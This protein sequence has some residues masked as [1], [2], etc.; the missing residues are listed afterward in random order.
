VI[1][2]PYLGWACGFFDFDLDGDEDL[3]MFN[4]H[5]YPE[6]TMSTMDSD[7]EQVPLL[8]A[9]DGRKFRRVNAETAGAWL[10]Q[11][12]RDRS[13]VFGDLDGDGDID[14]IVNELNGPIRVLRNDAL[15][16]AP[17]AAEWLIVTL[18]DDRADSKNRDGLG[19]R[20]ALR[21][22]GGRVQR[23]WIYSGGGFQSSDPHV[24]H[25]GIVPEERQSLTL[26][27]VWPDGLEQTIE[28]VQSNQRLIVKRGQ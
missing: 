17:P 16:P 18:S 7:Y 11:R 14:V 28:N 19:A 12:H 24:A 26:T 2:R 23:R 1:S 21:D 3:L 8:F 6:A 27:V 20:I 5:V 22:A 9:R 25:F 15:D 10:G 4:G 13:A